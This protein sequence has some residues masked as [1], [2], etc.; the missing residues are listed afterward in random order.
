MN[1]S[2]TK[3]LLAG[4]YIC[5]YRYP[6]E[7]EILQDEQEHDEIDAWLA[8]LERRIARLGTDGAFFMAPLMVTVD[9]QRQL[10]AAF[11]QFRDVYGPAVLMLDMIRQTDSL[12]ITLSPGEYIPLYELEQAV[13]NSST[14]EMQLKSKVLVI[15]NGSH[16]STVRENLRRLMDH[17]VKDGYLMLANKETGTFRVT[18]KIDQLYGVLQYLSANTVIPEVDADE[19]D[20]ADADLVDLAQGEQGAE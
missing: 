3:M 6:T 5:P 11:L 1:K 17:L 20:A 18:G 2:I 16:R 15:D 7:F 14:L 8:A 9:D 13:S 4:E 10:K 19:Q 12:N